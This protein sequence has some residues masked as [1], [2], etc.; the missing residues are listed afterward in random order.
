M[1]REHHAVSCETDCTMNFSQSTLRSLSNDITAEQE[2][3]NVFEKQIIV[4]W[5][6]GPSACRLHYKLEVEE[7][8]V[9]T[10][11]SSE[12]DDHSVCVPE[13]EADMSMDVCDPDGYTSSDAHE[14]EIRRLRDSSSV[15]SLHCFACDKLFKG[16]RSNLLSIMSH[17][18]KRHT[19][20]AR[21]S[22][23]K[24]WANYHTVLMHQ[25]KRKKFR[26]SN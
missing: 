1:A 17:V 8:H 2:G 13:Q 23:N 24:K 12:G 26:I 25:L 14:Y 11:I 4:S 6:K 5:N 10:E 21:S 9:K 7:F 15:P 3:S 19:R 20:L 16:E 18:S 22:S